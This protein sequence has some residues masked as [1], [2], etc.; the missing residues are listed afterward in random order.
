M[1]RSHFVSGYLVLAFWLLVAVGCAP[2]ESVLV[3]RTLSEV[4]NDLILGC[5]TLDRDYADYDAYKEYLAPLGMR[6]VRLQAGWAKCERQRG[7][8][9]FAWLD[10]IVDDAVSRG[11]EPWLE[12]SYGNPV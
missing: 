9:D 6:Y 10:H 2:R 7:V 1:R 8:Y 12:L 4:H 5:E 3:H 11:L